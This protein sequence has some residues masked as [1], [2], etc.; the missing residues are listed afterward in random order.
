LLTALVRQS[1]QPLVEDSLGGITGAH[2]VFFE[3]GAFRV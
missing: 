1:F 2:H 3:R